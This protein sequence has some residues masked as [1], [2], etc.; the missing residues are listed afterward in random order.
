MISALSGRLPN[1]DVRPIG[2]DREGYGQFLHHQHI[3]RALPQP[4]LF[5]RKR[6][7]RGHPSGGDQIAGPD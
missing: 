1:G 3:E 7:H 5:E 4:R 2:A 6:K